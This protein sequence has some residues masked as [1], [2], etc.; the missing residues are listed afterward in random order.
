MVSKEKEEG[1]YLNTIK[2]KLHNNP[3]FATSETYENKIV[4]F[5]IWS[6]GDFLGFLKDYQK[7]IDRK[8]TTIAVGNIRFIQTLL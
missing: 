2:L 6:P 4:I 7:S 3:F 5:E 1:K 8:T